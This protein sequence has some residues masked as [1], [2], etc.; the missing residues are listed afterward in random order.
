MSL[1][2]SRCTLLFRKSSLRVRAIEAKRAAGVVGH[3]RNLSAGKADAGGLLRSSRP[4]WATE[5]KVLSGRK[6]LRR[7][8]KREAGRDGGREGRRK[9]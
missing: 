8:R 4:L 2:L 6:T 3:I 7:K 1:R 9:I 5:S